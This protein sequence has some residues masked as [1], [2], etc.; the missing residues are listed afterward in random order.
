M[1]A[2]DWQ[3]YIC[4]PSLEAL[5]ASTSLLSA[6]AKPDCWW[7]KR[8]LFMLSRTVRPRRRVDMERHVLTP[9]A[10]YPHVCGPLGHMG[11]ESEPAGPFC[12][13]E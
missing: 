3:M 13:V 9:A 10:V 2:L 8:T 12:T 7:K 11:E 4:Y 6:P 5:P 1:G